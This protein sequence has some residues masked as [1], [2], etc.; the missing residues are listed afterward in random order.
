M[1]L[2]FTYGATPCPQ[3]LVEVW[4]LN[5]ERSSGEHS[6]VN[7]SATPTRLLEQ[8]FIIHL[9]L[10]YKHFDSTFDFSLTL[11]FIKFKAQFDP[12]N[13][14]K[15]IR[16]INWLASSHKR[17]LRHA[18]FVEGFVRLVNGIAKK[19]HIKVF[20]GEISDFV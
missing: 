15:I 2:R 10:T 1:I 6:A 4:G 19:L 8:E 12:A 20:I 3:A 17:T 9:Y 5:H 7:H 14:K 13:E 16:N 18:I 11:K